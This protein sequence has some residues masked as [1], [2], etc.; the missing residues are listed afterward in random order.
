MLKLMI[1]LTIFLSASTSKSNEVNDVDFK[2]LELGLTRSE[3]DE[4]LPDDYYY[5]SIEFVSDKRQSTGKDVPSLRSLYRYYPIFVGGEAGVLIVD[6]TFADPTVQTVDAYHWYRDDVESWLWPVE[7]FEDSTRHQDSVSN[8]TWLN[9]VHAFNGQFGKAQTSG[10]S[11]MVWGSWQLARC[12]D[13]KSIR[14]STSRTPFY[15]ACE[16]P[17][18]ATGL[19]EKPTIKS[20]KL[21]TSLGHF[22][23]EY[24]SFRVD[25]SEPL[26]RLSPQVKVASVSYPLHGVQGTMMLT[27]ESD[28]LVQWTWTIADRDQDFYPPFM[29]IVQPYMGQAEEIEN[30]DLLAAKWTS[31]GI[32]YTIIEDLRGGDL[33]ISSLYPDFMPRLKALFRQLIGN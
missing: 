15:G 12:S 18:Y 28:S 26:F 22:E 31:D 29:E 20:L 27:F 6:F 25:E 4:R 3:L 30:E 9:L 11:V 32:P 10:D 16:R 14:M 17:W 19:L 2:K 24:Q 1:I 8:K 33:M 5:D 21:G 7:L 23:R 13:R